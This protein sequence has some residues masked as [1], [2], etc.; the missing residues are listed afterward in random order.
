MPAKKPR[1]SRRLT[2]QPGHRPAAPILRTTLF[3][4]GDPSQKYTCDA[5][6]DTGA[7]ITIITPKIANRL[8][9]KP[10][11]PASVKGV[12]GQPDKAV[13]SMANIKIES[14]IGPFLTDIVIYNLDDYEVILGRSLMN[15]FTVLIK[16]SGEFEIE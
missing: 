6:Y 9:L 1:V 4:P 5:L 13:A 14:N 11:G 2:P 3:S 7:D 12:K 8:G 10:T 16:S 15:K